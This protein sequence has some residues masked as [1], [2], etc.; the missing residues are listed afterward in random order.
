MR[1]STQSDLILSQ[2]LRAPVWP[3]SWW[4]K[5]LCPDG[6]HFAAFVVDWL[7][8]PVTLFVMG[9]GHGL[10]NTMLPRTRMIVVRLDGRLGSA[11]AGPKLG[12]CSCVS[13]TL[14]T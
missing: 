1:K 9:E 3:A 11:C 12:F 2:P 10:W 13:C 5:R 7:E 14:F 8:L 4:W 6:K